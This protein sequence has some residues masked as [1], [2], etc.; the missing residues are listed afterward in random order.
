MKITYLKLNW[1]LPGAN[2]LRVGM[3]LDP[4]IPAQ[5]IYIIILVFCL[6]ETILLDPMFDVPGTDIVD[7]I[8]TDEVIKG[9]EKPQYIHQPRDVTPEAD[10]IE[11]QCYEDP[12]QEVSARNA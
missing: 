12:P 11:E 1:N 3:S 7:V 2:E 10:P 8:I 5:Q 9:K 6:Q 4:S